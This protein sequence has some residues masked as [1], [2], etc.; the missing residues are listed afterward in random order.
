MHLFRQG[1]KT[2]WLSILLICSSWTLMIAALLNF[3]GLEPSLAILES[4]LQTIS[5]IAGAWLLGNI[6]NFYIP[7]KGQLWIALALPII[8]AAGFTTLMYLLT[9]WISPAQEEYLSFLRKS[10][11]L[12]GTYIYL[13]YQFWT[14]LLLV[15]GKLEDQQHIKEKEI[16][17]AKLA[18]EAEMYHLRQQLQPH[19]LFNSLNSISALVKSQPDQ[20]REMVVELADFLRGT[21][22]KNGSQWIG[23]EEEIA[24]IHK[25]LYIEKVRFGSRLSVAIDQEERTKN[26]KIPQLMIQPLLE[27]AIKHGLYGMT[28]EVSIT[29]KIQDKNED[30]HITIQN[31]YDSQA[32]QAKGSG[33]GLEAVHRRLQLIFGRTDLLHIQQTTTSFLVELTIPQ[34]ATENHHY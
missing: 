26:F 18:K 3:Y 16:T 11:F 34:Y 21:I 20:A 25:F 24:Q 7:Q 1:I 6:F 2:Y 19:F 30:L 27:N 23:M 29:L 33:F 15:A 13:L 22:R 31:P 4:I 5:I 28:G 10:S 8:F 9:L 17:T 12:K 32:G 14:I